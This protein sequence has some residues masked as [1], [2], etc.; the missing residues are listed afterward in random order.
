[1]RAP[2]TRRAAPA[3]AR[4]P[5]RERG[6]TASRM[7]GAGRRSFR[8]R[9]KIPGLARPQEAHA[10]PMML[11]AQDGCAQPQRTEQKAA[12]A[13]R[14]A[15][16]PVLGEPA[17]VAAQVLDVEAAAVRGAADVDDLGTGI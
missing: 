16:T 1:M 12:H 4:P 8:L 17:Q 11:A 13:L 5:S 2:Q 6:R 7:R 10:F 14:L 3:R 15:Q 9:Q